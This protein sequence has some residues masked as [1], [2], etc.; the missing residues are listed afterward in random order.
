MMA[1]LLRGV[2]AEAVNEMIAVAGQSNAVGQVSGSSGLPS[3][4]V[5]T[6]RVQFWKAG[7]WETYDPANETNWG[8]EVGFAKAWLDA[9]ALGTLYIVKYAVGG[10]QLGQVSVYGQ[11]STATGDWSPET[12][13]SYYDTLTSRVVAAKAATPDVP[14]TDFLWIQGEADSKDVDAIADYADNIA[15]LYAAARSDW[16]APTLRV[17]THVVTRTYVEYDWDA[18]WA[19]QQIAAAVD[20]LA[21]IV[22]TEGLSYIDD[23]HLTQSGL[24][25]LGSTAYSLPRLGTTA[26]TNL[27]ISASTVADDAA[28]GAVIGTL[29]INSLDGRARAFTLLTASDDFEIV[30]AE[31]RV[32]TGATL[33]AGVVALSVR[34]AIAASGLYVED[35]INVTVTTEGWWNEDALIDLDYAN[36]RFYVNGIEYLSEAAMVTAG[37]YSTTSGARPTID[38]ATAGITLPA[39][40]SLFFDGVNKNA[41]V[42]SGLPEYAL[43]LDDGADAAATDQL[44]S[45]GRAIVNTNVPAHILTVYHASTV[46]VNTNTQ[47]VGDFAGANVAV[48]IAARI[49]S[50]SMDIAV[51]GVSSGAPDTSCTVPT[52]LTKFVVAGRSVSAFRDWGGTV[53]RVQLLTT[54]IDEA[55]LEAK[56]A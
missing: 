19:Q 56:T 55:G 33:E 51:N 18:L 1:T 40:Y 4:W 37:F 26:P 52:G 20:P 42:Q 38:L 50:N 29:D 10:S 23:I 47:F 53:G 27:T 46:Q 14:V 35:E 36:S 17:V 24:N 45:I 7:A 28:A 8:P 54:P 41:V 31:V 16:S 22:D 30:G 44:V 39:A 5:N 32:K 49:E 43:C 6:A 34:G 12:S 13:A 3:G 9:H 15:A 48:K 21:F 11:L 2:G 25:A